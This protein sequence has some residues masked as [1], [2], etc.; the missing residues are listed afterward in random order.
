MSTRPDSGRVTASVAV[1][2]LIAR[3]GSGFFFLLLP[4]FPAPGFPVLRTGSTEEEKTRGRLAAH[5]GLGMSNWSHQGQEWLSDFR[6]YRGDAS[7]CP[8]VVP[9]FDSLDESFPC[10]LCAFWQAN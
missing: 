10:R 2:L 5:V 8:D 7:S 9:L 1:P 6:R 4:T 3:V